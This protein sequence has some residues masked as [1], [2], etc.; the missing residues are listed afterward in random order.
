MLSGDLEK[1]KHEVQEIQDILRASAD[2]ILKLEVL[3]PVIFPLH[4][5][6]LKMWK[7]KSCLCF[8]IY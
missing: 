8:S 3:E 5:Q 4:C 2:S 1:Q 6:Q 7:K